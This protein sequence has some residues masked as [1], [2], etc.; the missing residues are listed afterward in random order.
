MGRG[1]PGAPE[2]PGGSL[3]FPIPSGQP[4]G[5]PVRVAEAIGKL[6][7]PEIGAKPSKTAVAEKV[8]CTSRACRY[9]PWRVGMASGSEARITDPR[10][11]RYTALCCIEKAA[12]TR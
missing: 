7:V 6:L 4:H 5:R 8:A 10:P 9:C 12:T 3:G 1:S 11:L 2:H